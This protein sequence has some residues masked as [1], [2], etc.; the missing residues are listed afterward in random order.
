MT[1]DIPINVRII[2]ATHRRLEQLV[3]EG[4]FREDLYYRINVVALTIPS[5]SER[6]EDIPLLANHF[7]QQ[8][9]TR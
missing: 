7:L 9:A 4:T 3:T 8:L 6:R 1:I 2:C 5:L